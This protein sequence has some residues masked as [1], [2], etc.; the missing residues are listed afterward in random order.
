MDQRRIRTLCSNLSARQKMPPHQL[1]Y[2]ADSLFL[3]GRWNIRFSD[4]AFAEQV[5]LESLKVACS[6]WSQTLPQRPLTRGST[7]A[8]SIAPATHRVLHL[9]GKRV[10]G[11]AGLF[12]CVAGRCFSAAGATLRG[13]TERNFTCLDGHVACL[14]FL[15]IFEPK[16]KPLI[17]IIF[18]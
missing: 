2:G 15:T 1:A 9:P 18:L 5:H 3:A 13:L 4:A 14:L 12:L 10:R 11:P 8:L 6:Q 17:S 16:N 7:P